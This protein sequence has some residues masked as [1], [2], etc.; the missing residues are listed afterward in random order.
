MRKTVVF[1]GGGTGGH[2]FP[3]LAVA[4][5]LDLKVVFIGSSFG[6]ERDLV[7]KYGFPFRGVPIRGF[8]GVPRW[9]QAARLPLLAWS[10]VRVFFHFIALRPRAVLGFGGYASIPALFWA[11]LLAIPYFL[12]EQNSVPGVVTRKFAAAAR[13]VFTAYP[14]LPLPGTQV[15]TGNPVREEIRAVRRQGTPVPPLRVLVLGGSQGSKFL[16]RLFMETAPA[17]TAIPLE[18]FHQ[19]GPSELAAVRS[20]YAAAG[21]NAHTEAFIE[22][23]DEAYAWANLL[24]CRAGAMTVSESI[25]SGRPAHFI[26]FAGA[27]HDHQL[28]NARV[29][30]F[31]GAAFVTEERAMTPQTLAVF[32]RAVLEDPTQLAAMSQI[33]KTLDTPGGLARIGEALREAVGGDDAITE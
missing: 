2:I 11:R 26:P 23:M 10:V 16:N 8:V 9:K 7:P 22:R 12:Q 18:L 31:Q 19:T 33:L 24:V 28:H 14:N 29:L 4:R 21:V 3:A 30:A 20:A 27:T 25:A 5:S 15:L 1:A 13:A 32:L 17:L 6:M